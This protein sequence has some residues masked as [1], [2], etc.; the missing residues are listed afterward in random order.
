[1]SPHLHLLERSNE[2]FFDTSVH[3]IPKASSLQ[4]EFTCSC[5][6]P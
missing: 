2:A 1:M 3:Q 5:E 4:I 6:Q